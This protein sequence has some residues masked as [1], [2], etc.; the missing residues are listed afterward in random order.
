MSVF[1]GLAQ[2]V[3][4]TASIERL[5]HQP[6]ETVVPL[7]PALLECLQDINWPV[8]GAALPILARCGAPAARAAQ[9]ILDAAQRDD[10]WKYWLV[11]ALFPA[12]PPD[13]RAIMEP[14]VR[15]IAV[16]SCGRTGGGG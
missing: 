12:L 14:S 7:I 4:D 2:S 13:A 15:R 16:I 9:A 10:V 11:E 8:A 6:P 3:L 5:V 1:G